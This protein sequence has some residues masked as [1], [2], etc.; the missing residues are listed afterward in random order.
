M[1]VAMAY[2]EVPTEVNRTGDWTLDDTLEPIWGEATVRDAAIFVP[3]AEQC[4][5]RSPTNTPAPTSWS[6]H[7]VARRHHLVR[8]ERM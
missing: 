3:E 6:P 4:R 1:C 7:G 8:T 2:A 5:T